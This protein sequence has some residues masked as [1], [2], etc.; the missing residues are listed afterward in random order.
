MVN[1]PTS[2]VFGLCRR[3]RPRG[4]GEPGARPTSTTAP[5]RWPASWRR[6]SSP[7]RCSTSRS[8]PASAGTCSAARS[9]AILVGPWVGALCVA[10][11][12]VVQ[13]LLFADGGLTALGTNITNM[14]LIGVVRRLR[15]RVCAAPVRRAQPRRPAG[16]RRSSPRWSAPWSPRWASSSSTRS[17]ARGGA[18]LGTVV[19]LDGRAAR[20]DRHRRGPDHRGH[21]RRR[22]GRP[23]RPRVPAA[24]TP[25]AAT[26]ARAAARPSMSAPDPGSCSA[27]LLVALVSPAA[28]SYFASSE[29]GRA[30][31]DRPCTAAPSRDRRG[32][33]LDGDCIAQNATEHPMAGGPLADYAVGGGGAPTGLAGILGVLVTLRW[34]RAACSGCSAR[35]GARP[36]QGL[37]GRGR[38][39]RAS[40]VPAG[41]LGGAPAA[42]R[43]EDRRGVARRVSAWWRRRARRSGRSAC[44]LLGARRRVGGRRDPARLDRRAAR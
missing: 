20:A 2:L 29:P 40:A 17:A 15:G 9:S 35:P 32:E 11:V 27:S 10:I 3:P 31:R 36:R 26:A 7:S 42:G 43:G 23:A 14:A 19:A 12:L 41:R 34:S 28:L 5:R 18:G 8:C 25:P 44:Y 6:S 22:R 16:R 13:A 38:G 39:P 4:R 24:R 30:G 21:G 33:Q 37:T 1:A